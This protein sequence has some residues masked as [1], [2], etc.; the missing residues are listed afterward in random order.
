MKGSPVITVT[1]RKNGLALLGMFFLS[2]SFRSTAYCQQPPA[3]PPESPVFLIQTAPGSKSSAAAEQSAS[4]KYIG[5]IWSDQK[6][7]WSSPF[8]MKRRQWLA[9]A[10]PL[11]VGTAA[12]LASDQSAARALPNTADQS[13]WS[14]RVSNIGA[15]GAMGGM[16][17]GTMLYG[18]ARRD[19][20]WFKIGVS[21][22]RALA[23]SFIVCTSLKYLTAR[24]R[25]TENNGEGRF[26]KGGDSFPSAHTMYSFTVAMVIARNPRT[27]KWL[28]VT[29]FGVSTVVGLARWGAQRHFPSDVVIGG[30]LGSLI[31]NYVAT[32]QR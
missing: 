5:N 28:K 27:P 7:I 23:D 25:P 29:A 15:I 3:D 30:V 6:A 22:S 31:G 2:L 1:R 18:K 13:I 14:R 17:G 12:L 16:V 32:R 10:L 21:A 19:P 26:W 11:A 9:V 4:R 24:E 20:E 8:R